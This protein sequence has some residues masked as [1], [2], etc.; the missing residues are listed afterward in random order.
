MMKHFEN[1]QTRY[2]RLL[3]CI[4]SFNLNSTG[5]KAIKL[6]TVESKI[7]QP[8]VWWNAD[9]CFQEQNRELYVVGSEEV[10]TSVKEIVF[11]KVFMMQNKTIIGVDIFF[12]HKISYH[13]SFQTKLSEESFHRDAHG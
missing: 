9:F 10:H 2:V 8:L 5:T 7:Q 13:T 4:S 12:V 11:N 1:V 3:Q 6:I